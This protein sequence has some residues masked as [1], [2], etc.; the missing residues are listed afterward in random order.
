MS[1]KNQI[2]WYKYS[3][4]LIYGFGVFSHSICYDLVCFDFELTKRFI[5]QTNVE[6]N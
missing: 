2:D 1:Y 4:S 3:H 5:Q 6:M